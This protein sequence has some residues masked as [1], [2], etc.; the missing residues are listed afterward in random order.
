MSSNMKILCSPKAVKT[1]SCETRVRI[2]LELSKRPM[3]I[4]Q[5]AKLLNKKPSTI[6]YHIHK[7]MDLGLVKLV[8]MKILTQDSS[9]NT[10]RRNCQHHALL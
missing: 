9:K 5:L 10:I 6:L 4:S 8:R 3:T 1:L 7:L 2:L